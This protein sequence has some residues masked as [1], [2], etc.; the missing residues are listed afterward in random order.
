MNTVCVHM[1]LKV[2]NSLINSMKWNTF[3][4]LQG[5]VV[6]ERKKQNNF[7]SLCN[8]LYIYMHSSCAYMYIHVHEC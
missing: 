1:Y 3:I 2:A 6:V 8:L 5:K 7:W 4:Q